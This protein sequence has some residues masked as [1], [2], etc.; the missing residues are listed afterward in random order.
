M[1]IYSKFIDEKGMG[2]FMEYINSQITEK[3][4]LTISKYLILSVNGYFCA[5]KVPYVHKIVELPCVSS[6]SCAEP[7]IL[8]VTKVGGEVYT[9]LDLCVLFGAEPRVFSQRTMAVLLTYEESK[10]CVVV[11][12]VLTVTGI[13]IDS[14]IYPFQKKCCIYGAV[15]SDDEIICLLSMDYLFRLGNVSNILL[16]K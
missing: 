9:V 1:C 12:D 14:A 8:G 11:D 15:Q 16:R 7:Y 6:L 10:I 5:V 4:I 3:G 2:R 13:D